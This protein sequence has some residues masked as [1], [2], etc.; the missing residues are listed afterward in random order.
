MALKKEASGS[1]TLYVAH[2]NHALRGSDADADE[3]WLKALCQRWNVPLE[4]GRAN[5]SEIAVQHGD[6]LE[7]AARTARY[8]FL[9]QTAERLGAR[10]VATAHTSDDQ[11][12]T[13]LHRLVRG[14]GLA[15]LAGI[16]ITRPISPS[17]TL[18]RPLLDV[19]RRVRIGDH[20]EPAL[21]GRARGHALP[22]ARGL[23]ARRQP[24]A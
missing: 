15:G 1:G 3:A 6:G 8:D 22:V 21:L 18:V 19:R 7:A 11:V 14:T 2:L 10:F 4:L 24:V 5:V 13:V 16:P 9:R 23:D 17:V 20:Q 12:E